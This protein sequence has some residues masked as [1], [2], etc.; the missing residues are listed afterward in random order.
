MLIQEGIT[1]FEFW[2]GM[3]SCSYDE[4]EDNG[5]S[6]ENMRRDHVAYRRG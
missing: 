2:I 1:D 5:S 6:H 3:K 4:R